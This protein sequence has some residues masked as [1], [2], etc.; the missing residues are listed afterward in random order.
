MSK[1]FP[2][3]VL[4]PTFEGI[5]RQLE[6]QKLV[7]VSGNWMHV[8]EH[9]DGRLTHR[10][11]GL[12]GRCHVERGVLLL[13]SWITVRGSDSDGAPQSATLRFN[14]VT[15]HLMAPFFDALRP[16]PAVTASVDLELEREHFNYLAKTHYKFY[17]H[18]RSCIRPGDHIQLALLQPEL[19]SRA[20]RI[21]GYSISRRLS[22]T[23]LTILTETE[24]VCIRDD[25]KSNL[26]RGPAPGAIWSYIPRGLIK[27][28]SFSSPR[29]GGLLA[30]EIISNVGP[31]LK[32]TFAARAQPELMRL[33]RNLEA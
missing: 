1:P 26:D 2:Y 8:L 29:D 14:S 32:L 24:L 16:R 17:S 28:A 10:S 11:F 9:G 18:G 4:T 23:H 15:D 25:E 19:R 31:M 33:V 20:L 21:F 22:P 6:R 5:G 13:H 30:L 3:C 7:C 27:G 12:N